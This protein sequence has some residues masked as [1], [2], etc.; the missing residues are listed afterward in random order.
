MPSDFKTAM[1]K[2][3][4]LAQEYAIQSLRSC[5][6]NR[7][8]HFAYDVYSDRPQYEFPNILVGGQQL[9][10]GLSGFLLSGKYAA[11][12]VSAVQDSGMRSHSVG[13]RDLLSRCY[14]IQLDVSRVCESFMD[15][16]YMTSQRLRPIPSVCRPGGRGAG[17]WVISVGAKTRSVVRVFSAAGFHGGRAAGGFGG[18]S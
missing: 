2:L 13:C 14:A 15:P 18:G 11:S 7:L 17:G 16:A 8:V 1:F 4:L 3:Y 5:E 12:E 6:K 9:L 10:P